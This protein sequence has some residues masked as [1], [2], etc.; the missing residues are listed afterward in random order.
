[1]KKKK[2]IFL[3]NFFSTVPQLHESCKKQLF[4]RKAERDTKQ[5]H[6]NKM[7]A[8]IDP[9]ALDTLTCQTISSRTSII[10]YSLPL[11]SPPSLPA[12][13]NIYSRVFIHK[14]AFMCERT[15]ARAAI[16]EKISSLI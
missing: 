15:A 16:A 1:M 12:D 7:A 13:L 10:P 2:S 9:R 8:V 5:A 14:P 3:S 4:F 6:T 11:P